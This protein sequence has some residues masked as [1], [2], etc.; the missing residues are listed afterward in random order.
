[1]PVEHRSFQKVVLLEPIIAGHVTHFCKKKKK[2]KNWP[3][4]IIVIVCVYNIQYCIFNC[5]FPYFYIYI[6]SI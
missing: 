3:I 2:N 1:M 4:L 5:A 6:A